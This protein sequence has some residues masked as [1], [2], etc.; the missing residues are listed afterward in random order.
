MLTEGCICR[1]A[2]FARVGAGDCQL[3]GVS[4]FMAEMLE[5]AAIL[6][7][8]SLRSSLQQSAA[9]R[10][11]AYSPS[12]N[13][14][15][16]SMSPFHGAVFLLLFCSMIQLGQAVNFCWQQLAVSALMAE[17]LDM[18]A[19]IKIPSGCPCLRLSGGR[20]EPACSAACRNHRICA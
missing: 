11:S 10:S 17:M 8:L 18:V 9:L 6:K 19:I 15:N 7:V 12:F 5:T 1:D 14:G 20:P 16:G 13:L 2:I 3:R 4:T